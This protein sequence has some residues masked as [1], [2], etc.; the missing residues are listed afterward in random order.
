MDILNIIPYSYDKLIL[1]ILVMARISALLSTFVLFRKDYINTKILISLSSMVSFFA[2]ITINNHQFKFELFSLTMF[3]LVIFEVFIG[4]T[5]G[6]ILNIVF[7]IFT[8]VGQIISTQVGFS[9]ITLIDPRFGA[10]TPLTLFYNYSAILIFLSLDGHLLILKIILESFQALPVN[11]TFIPSD[12]LLSILKYT[13]VIFSGSVALSI[14]L[15]VTML[16]TNL[17][18]AVMSRFAPQFNIFSIGINISIILGLVFVLLTFSMFADNGIRV[19]Q[20]GL[21]YFQGILVGRSNG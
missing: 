13:K 2:M 1:F 8:A 19:I 16:L 4:I 5:A 20:D 17:T 15:I 21:L 3:M 9:M 6:L 10:I 7:E 11:T 12:L 14:P 18:I